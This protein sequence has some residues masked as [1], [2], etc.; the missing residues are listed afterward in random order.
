[1]AQTHKEV[2]MGSNIVYVDFVEVDDSTGNYIVDVSL[3][4]GTKYQKSV[5]E[6][7][8]TRQSL[9]ERAAGAKFVPATSLEDDAF[10]IFLFLLQEAHGL[11]PATHIRSA[12]QVLSQEVPPLSFTVEELLPEGATLLVGKPKVGKS[13]LSF[14]IAMAVASGSK[15]LG[16]STHKGE[17]LYLALEDGTR[18]L[19]SRLRTLGSLGAEA[20]RNLHLA[21]SWQPLEVGG[22]SFF[23]AW[24]DEHC[25]RLV[26]IDVLQK[27]RSPGTGRNENAY[28]RDYRS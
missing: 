27:L 7:A 3:E 8:L 23:E 18:R 2:E 1:V 10:Y 20:A 17:V 28:E 25:P 19:N 26:V 21:T 12:A 13:W 15:V 22:L 4:D 14:Q 6:F 9:F 11:R 5:P 16:R 24:I